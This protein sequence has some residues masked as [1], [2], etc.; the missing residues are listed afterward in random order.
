MDESSTYP[1]WNFDT[2]VKKLTVKANETATVTY[3]NTHH[4]YAKLVKQTNTGANLS[5]W[6]INVYTDST[7]KN[8]VSGSPFTTGTDGTIAVRLTPGDYWCR[9]VDES[10]THPDWI[11]DTNAKKV[12]VKAGQTASV[13]FTN[14]Q[15]G[16]GK[17]IKSMPDGGAAEGWV[18]DVYRKSDGAHMGTFTSGADGSILTGY[19]YPGD[20]EVYEQIPKDSIYYCE[21]PNPQ[22]VTI[23]AGKTANVTF[24]NRLK[25]AQIII[26]KVDSLG[27][28]LAEAEFLLEWS[29]DGSSWSPVTYS[30]SAYVSKGTCASL[31]LK[32]GKLESGRDGVVCFEGLHPELR[33]RLT[34]TKAPAGYQLLTGPAYEGGIPTGENLIVELTVVN[35]PVYELPM[36]GSKSFILMAVSL[37][38][39][40]VGCIGTLMDPRRKDQ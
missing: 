25:P 1:D 26:Y 17:L 18:F 29:E 15:L 35:A 13:T 21:S 33:Y 22:T 27:V 31:G 9:E 40:I 30:D 12:T 38:I 16:R 36:T 2:S 7:C 37:Y 5:G 3:T 14:T 4:G 11:Y 34:E 24:V 20:Y 39:C 6:K 10:S 8:L 32:N 19:L 28:P 23:T